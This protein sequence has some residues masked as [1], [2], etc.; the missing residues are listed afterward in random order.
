MTNKK[1]VYA[2]IVHKI[3]MALPEYMEHEG[4]DVMPNGSFRCPNIAGHSNA[5]RN[6]SGF[7]KHDR[8]DGYPGWHCYKC[9]LGGDSF[10]LATF[11]HDVPTEGNGFAVETI[12]FL[13][14]RLGFE[15]PEVKE[16]ELEENIRLAIQ[17]KRYIVDNPADV[18]ELTGPRFGRNYSEALA[19]AILD[20]FHICKVPDNNADTGNPIL[21]HAR[22]GVL[23][24]PIQWDGMYSGTVAR[25]P[26]SVDERPK[27]E[28]SLKLQDKGIYY[29]PVIN[30]DRGI[31]MAKR[32]GILYIFEGVFNSLSAYAVGLPAV[33]VLGVSNEVSIIERKLTGNKAIREVVICMDKDRPGIDSAFSIGKS[34]QS[35]GI[36]VGFLDWMNI[37]DEDTDYD[38]N[39][40][41]Q[42]TVFIDKIKD[43]VNRL[44]LMEYV[45][46]YKADYMFDTSLS[47]VSKYN[48]LISDIS[49]YGSPLLVDSYSKLIPAGFPNLRIDATDISVNIKE[50]LRDSNSPL[51]RQLDKLSA[52]FAGDINESRSIE[53]KQEKIRSLYES[54]QKIIDAGG[55]NIVTIA[56]KKMEEL[57]TKDDDDI[58]KVFTTG[59]EN[60]DS[61]SKTEEEGLFL[62]D[63]ML[64]GIAGKPSHIK[65]ALCRKLAVNF[66]TLHKDDTFVVYFTI[67][68]NKKRAYQW[69]VATSSG[70]PFKT[71]IRASNRAT[72]NSV[73][74]DI[75]NTIGEHKERLSEILGYNLFM[76][77]KEE[78]GTTEEIVNVVKRFHESNPGKWGVF[79]VDNMYNVNNISRAKHDKRYAAE[80]YIDV[81]KEL[82]TTK[83][84]LFFNT[85]EVVKNFSGRIQ[86]MHLKETGAV[87]FRND[88]TIATFNSWK[89]W[90]RRSLMYTENDGIITPVTEVTVLK[91]KIGAPG[92]TYF[93]DLNGPTC[94]L[95]PIIDKVRINDLKLRMDSDNG[96]Q[97]TSE[98][99]SGEEEQE[100]TGSFDV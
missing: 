55:G 70:I 45:I 16:S 56:K 51:L 14:E 31:N 22:K 26:V 94:R 65:S 60:I 34:M 6:R 81:V 42:G 84:S 28:N 47:D 23:L 68:D 24:I 91:D 21:H 72:S 89:E 100:L 50:A 48:N 82:T 67:D 41:S 13:C 46:K 10:D 79:M 96:R 43:T 2:N 92:E 1:E 95:H 63:S 80:E 29:P 97:R 87:D 3:K 61:S 98:D 77:D 39:F 5:D 37:T 85:L 93:F 36:N 44:S 57:R 58:N 69:L 27:Y 73:S 83:K 53:S 19:I 99:G 18:T 11:I 76:F 49:M 66:A 59:C 7:F 62:T 8:G 17:A 52:K 74:K 32:L 35:Q 20:K 4:I 40:S 30:L 38:E 54:S 12:P 25:N 90:K 15:L 78:A 9:L 88:I 86:A 71:V 64:V 33:G 75:L